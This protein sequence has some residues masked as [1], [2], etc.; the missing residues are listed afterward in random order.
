MDAMTELNWLAETSH[1]WAL[2][3]LA[4]GCL[5]SLIASGLWNP[6]LDGPEAISPNQPQ[7]H[8]PNAPRV[9]RE[10]HSART[11]RLSQR[12]LEILQTEW[13]CDFAHDRESVTFRVAVPHHASRTHYPRQK[14]A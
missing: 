1:G 2:F 14:T 10:T 3:V 4:T 9:R 11:G 8:H 5:V 7:D 13:H 12:H 6:P